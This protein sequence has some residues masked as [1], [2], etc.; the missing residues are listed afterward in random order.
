MFVSVCTP[1]R[2]RTPVAVLIAVVAAWT[3]IA[4]APR[5]AQASVGHR[6]YSTINH[7]S[8]FQC[9]VAVIG[10]PERSC[11]QGEITSRTDRVTSICDAGST[12]PW[13][14]AWRLVLNLT[15]NQVGYM[16]SGFLVSFGSYVAPYCGG[17][18][19]GVK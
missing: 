8:L 19:E 16:D 2:W 18:G 5:A 15:N 11:N 10:H 13:G 12:S 7:A 1:A 6:V 4:F 17:V 9:P 14:H 3:A